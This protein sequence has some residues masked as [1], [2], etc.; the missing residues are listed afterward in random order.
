MQLKWGGRL[1]LAG[2]AAF[3]VFVGL[4]AG[5]PLLAG[6]QDA[7]EQTCHDTL[8]NIK[9]ETARIAWTASEEDKKGTLSLKAVWPAKTALNRTICLVFA[10][11]VPA[12]TEVSL[13]KAVERQSTALSSKQA[14]YDLALSQYD[15]AE[16]ALNDRKNSGSTNDTPPLAT[17][18][19]AVQDAK[20]RVDEQL[21]LRDQ[22]S[23]KLREA[24]AAAAKGLDPVPLHVFFNDLRAD[25][26]TLKARPISAPQMLLVTLEPDP[27]VSSNT[28]SFWRKLLH[29]GTDI[30]EKKISI[31]LSRGL[32]DAADTR[33]DGA[34]TIILFDWWVVLIGAVSFLCFVGSFSSHALSSSLIRNSQS[35]VTADE[36]AKDIIRLNA[37]IAANAPE[38]EAADATKARLAAANEKAKRALL[39]LNTL[40]IRGKKQALEQSAF[41]A[42]FDLNTVPAATAYS[43]FSL[44]KTQMAFWL[45]LT[46]AGFVFIWLTTGQYMNLVTSGI[47]VLVGISGTTGLAAVQLQENMQQ[48]QYSRGF[49][50]DILSDNNGPQLYR[51]QAAAWTVILGTIFVWNIV[52]NFSFPVFDTNLLIMM[53]I[54]STLYI[55]FKAQK[56]LTE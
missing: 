22:F 19:K 18:E 23:D 51:V 40:L 16:K 34:M 15:E 37:E 20:K 21:K 25:H 46:S 9:P 43:P 39:E 33:I 17:L 45:F 8:Q 42:A 10:G 31:G 29:S 5:Y 2:M 44:G 50:N 36:L 30:S 35:K 55:G 3:L 53:G 47:L 11:A 32:T 49:L 4:S 48:D 41:N 13:S 14:D 56:S 7:T 38:G 27:D 1:F 12:D 24:V 26:I 28:A 52:Y 54:S 6:L